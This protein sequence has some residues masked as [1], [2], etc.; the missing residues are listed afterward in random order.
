ME[1]PKFLETDGIFI[2]IQGVS[3]IDQDKTDQ[4][5]CH[6]TIGNE[7]PLR[8]NI[9]AEKLA[10]QKSFFLVNNLWINVYHIVVIKQAEGAP[11]LCEVMLSSGKSLRIGLSA[12]KLHSL[13]GK[14][15]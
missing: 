12:K 6:I 8:I 14:H 7:N 3:L 9:S 10:D 2:N 5:V 13:L 11:E 15:I 4:D 1:K